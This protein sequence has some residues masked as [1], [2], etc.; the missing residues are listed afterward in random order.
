MEDHMID[1]DS[2]EAKAFGLTSDLFDGYLWRKG[3]QIWV[4]MII[5]KEPGQ[6]HFKQ[7]VKNIEDAGYKV[8]VPCPLGVMPEILKHWGFKP[9]HVFTGDDVVEIWTRAA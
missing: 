3:D 8:V 7:V 1:V 9:G 4:S 5:S 6:G 2:N